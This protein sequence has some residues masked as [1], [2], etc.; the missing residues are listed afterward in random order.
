MTRLTALPILLT[1]IPGLGSV[2]AEDK[3]LFNRDIRPLL[4]D[5]CFAC[6]GPD[7]HERKAKLR[8]D[9][10]EG[11]AYENRDGIIPIVPNNPDKSEIILRLLADD[12]DDLMPPKKSGQQNSLNKI[13]AKKNPG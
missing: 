9:I 6:H 5:N 8:L 11:G 7:E 12:E 1:I 2:N 4:S 10:K 13:R 3:L